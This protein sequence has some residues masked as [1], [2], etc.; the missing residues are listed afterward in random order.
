MAELNWQPLTDYLLTFLREELARQDH[1]ATGALS[2]SLRVEVRSAGDGVATVTGYG[3]GYGKYVNRG[4]TAGAMPPS[5]AI[6][7]WIGTRGIGVGMKEYQKRGLAFV[8]ARSIAQRG[9]PPAGGYSAF[10][11]KGNAIDRTRFVDKIF[12]EHGDEITKI[13]QGIVGENFDA[14]TENFWKRQEQK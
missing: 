8:I 12:E 13:V 7:N 11:A 10:Y 3:K 14:T 1:N 9:I 2:N 5:S 6:Y 4:R